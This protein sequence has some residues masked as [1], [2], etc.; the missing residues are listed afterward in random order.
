MAEIY[1][2]GQNRIFYKASKDK[3]GLVVTANIFDPS[4]E[5]KSHHVFT[6]VPETQRIYSADV[7]FYTEGIWIAI[8]Y[9]DE[10]EGAVE[11]TVQAY[12]TKKFPTDTRSRPFLGDNVING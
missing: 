5:V 7:D 9:E 3:D 12:N 11:K 4:L 2:L 8:F 1:P 10:G 6:K